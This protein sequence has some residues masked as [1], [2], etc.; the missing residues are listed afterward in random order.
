MPCN[1]YAFDVFLASRN[2]L[3]FTDTLYISFCSFRRSIIITSYL[4]VYIMSLCLNE[5]EN[6]FK[7]YN[8]VDV[9][10][11]TT[12]GIKMIHHSMGTS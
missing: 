8:A 3:H 1:V 4:V 7:T 10:D 12:I 5:I 11:I 6:V 9:L 2:G